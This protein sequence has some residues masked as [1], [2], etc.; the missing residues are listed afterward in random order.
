LKEGEAKMK[1]NREQ[2]FT[3]RFAMR[4]D[5]LWFVHEIQHELAPLI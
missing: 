1:M 4:D 3:G 2:S 5:R